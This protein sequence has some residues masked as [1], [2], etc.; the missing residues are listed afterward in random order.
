M[1]YESIQKH[2]DNIMKLDMIVKNK[3]QNSA[4]R[5]VVR[6]SFLVNHAVDSIGRFET[7]DRLI[8]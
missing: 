4:I 7:L 8:A 2:F 6:Y 1:G 5:R 3:V